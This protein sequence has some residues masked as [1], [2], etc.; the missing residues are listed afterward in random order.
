M[1]AYPVNAMVR[2][3]GSEG[4][5]R[6]PAPLVGSAANQ[7]QVAFQGIESHDDFQIAPDERMLN[8]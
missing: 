5:V 3:G 1:Q 7:P 2:K 4:G 8:Q 6:G